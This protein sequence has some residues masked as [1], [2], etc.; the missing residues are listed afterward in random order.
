MPGI[1]RK[2]EIDRFYKKG[3]I[4][5]LIKELFSCMYVELS[6]D[7]IKTPLPMGSDTAESHFTADYILRRLHSV[8]GGSRA[9]SELVRKFN[10]G[11]IDKEG[12]TPEQAKQEKKEYEKRMKAEGMYK[13]PG[14]GW[15]NRKPTEQDK[16]DHK[17]FAKQMKRW[18]K[19]YG[20]MR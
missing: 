14:G 4:D 1:S 19:K 16:K 12:R 6:K 13:M 2:R 5:A 3:D 10:A 8:P 7:G 20:F 9:L 15:S 18:R 17:K 11:K